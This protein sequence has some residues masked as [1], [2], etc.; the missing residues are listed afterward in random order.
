MHVNLESPG[1]T[2]FG[3]MRSRGWSTADSR[4][5]RAVLLAAAR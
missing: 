2:D 1:I 4:S 5:L 3:E